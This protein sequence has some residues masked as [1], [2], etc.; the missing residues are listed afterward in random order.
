VCPCWYKL[1]YYV[2]MEAVG[3]STTCYSSVAISLILRTV[4]MRRKPSSALQKGF[5]YLAFQ[6]HESSWSHRSELSGPRTQ[7]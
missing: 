1:L 3:A 6:L 4:A 5:V 7:L 2:I